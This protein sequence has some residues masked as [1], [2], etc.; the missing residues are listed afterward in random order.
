MSEK[1]AFEDLK[2]VDM[3]PYEILFI[4]ITCIVDK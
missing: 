2:F 1:G 4:T 3:G